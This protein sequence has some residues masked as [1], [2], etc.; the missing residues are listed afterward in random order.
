MNNTHHTSPLTV[1]YT[2]AEVESLTGARFFWSRH[3]EWARDE[4]HYSTLSKNPNGTWSLYT[5]YGYDAQEGHDA[6]DWQTFETLEGA[7]DFL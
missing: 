3:N 6:E 2:E 5:N 7:L 1:G 4:K